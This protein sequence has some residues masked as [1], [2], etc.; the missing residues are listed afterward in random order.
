[1]MVKVSMPFREVT[2]G[3]DPMKAIQGNRTHGHPSSEGVDSNCVYRDTYT[4]HCLAN[5]FWLHAESRSL[6]HVCRSC[7][8]CME[9][10]LITKMEADGKSAAIDMKPFV[11]AFSQAIRPRMA[12]MDMRL[13]SGKALHFRLIGLRLPSYVDVIR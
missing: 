10:D 8:T 4:M 13:R 2:R 12:Q 9:R 6:P 7:T 1:M 3:S 5:K 11:A